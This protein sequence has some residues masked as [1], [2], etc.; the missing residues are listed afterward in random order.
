M[1]RGQ[2]GSPLGPLEKKQTGKK[3]KRF[4]EAVILDD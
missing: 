4:K 2:S 1:S 3:K